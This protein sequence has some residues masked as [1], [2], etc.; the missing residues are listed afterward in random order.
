MAYLLFSDLM[1]GRISEGVRNSAIC[2]PR[3]GFL[4][5]YTGEKSTFS[6]DVAA[7]CSPDRTPSGARYSDASRKVSGEAPLV[8][9]AMFRLGGIQ[10]S[11]RS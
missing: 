7:S 6:S 5:M 10:R 1:S 2:F 11:P 8:K 9:V 3:V 4:A